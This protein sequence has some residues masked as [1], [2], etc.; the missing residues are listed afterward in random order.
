VYSALATNFYYAYGSDYVPFQQAGYVIT[1]L[2][3]TIESTYPHTTGDNLAHLDTSYV[4][5]VAK[6]ATGA[7]L[8][9]A[10]AYDLY[11]AIGQ[12]KA[13]CMVDIFPNPFDENISIRNTSENHVNIK[14]YDLNGREITAFQISA[15]SEQGSRLPQLSKGLYIFEISDAGGNV[16]ERKKISKL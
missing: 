6:A 1:G 3:E 14:V 9:F 10:K 8:Y 4:F 13:Y 12:D 5:E 7:S 15:L 16:L 11:T 2:Y